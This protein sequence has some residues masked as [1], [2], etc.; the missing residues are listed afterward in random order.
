MSFIALLPV[1]AEDIFNVGASGLGFM[2]GVEGMGGLLGLVLATML[3][4]YTHKGRLLIAG[5]ALFG[6]FLVMFAF[7]N[8]I[9]LAL[10]ALFCGAL[11]SQLYMVVTQTTLQLMVPDEVRGRVMGLYG[12]AYNIQPLGSMQMGILAGLMSA[13]I[14]VAIGGIA[15]A[16]Y[17]MGI[18]LPNPRIRRLVQEPAAVTTTA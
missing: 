1:F 6:A 11:C 16:A 12:V 7:S 17:S 13:P 2:Y 5:A 3:S 10:V 18:A 15:V 8:F 14:A 9:L 4:H